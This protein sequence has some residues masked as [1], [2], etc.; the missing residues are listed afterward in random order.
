MS[1]PLVSVVLPVRDGARYLPAALDSLRSQ[2]LADIELICIDDASSDATAALLLEAASADARIKVVTNAR[3]RGLPASLNLGFANASGSFH[4]WASH[5]NLAHPTM[6]ERLHAA[7]DRSPD[8]AIAYSDYEEI[9]A[10]GAPVG[11]QA[12]RPP[13]HLLLAN[14]VGPAFLYRAKVWFALGGYDEAL[15]GVEDY[16]FWLRAR[17]RFG[18]ARVEG[19]LLRYRLHPASMSST[20]AAE[21]AGAHDRLLEREIR[22]EGEA[23]AEAAA[24]LE[25]MR[26]RSDSKRLRY[27]PN[28]FRRDPS[29][30]LRSS[31]VNWRWL[32]ASLAAAGC[33][34]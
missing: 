31:L 17:H 20:R 28:A 1:G 16:D 14:V 30:T 27:L 32:Q 8:S 4:S 29:L 13:S 22:R 7:L 12:A 25:L 15:E 6:L 3:R 24:W 21:I 9:D 2:T 23:R 18:F 34:S 10:N 33:R 26:L 5:D 11:R 19:N